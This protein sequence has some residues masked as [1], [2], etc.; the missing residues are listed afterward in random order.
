MAETSMTEFDDIVDDYEDM[1]AE[2][3]KASGFPPAYFD[4]YKLREVSRYLARVGWHDRAVRFLNFGCGIGKSE[5]FIRHYLPASRIVSVDVSVKSLESA[6]ERNKNLADVSF[7]VFDGREIPSDEPFHVAFVANVFHHIPRAEHAGTIRA[8]H[9]S[10]A[11]GGLLFLFEHNPIN[12]LTV[13]AIKACPFDKGVV[14]LHPLYTRRLCTENGFPPPEVRFTLFF[15]KPL[16]FMIPFERYLS[17]LPIGAQYY[18]VA[19]KGGVSQ[20]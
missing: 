11:P 5:P 16:A 12:P 6:R 10:L 4:E 15:P 8:I 2:N 20:P 19:R 14:L 3:V 18:V 9:R 1:H 7:A 17:T 13:K